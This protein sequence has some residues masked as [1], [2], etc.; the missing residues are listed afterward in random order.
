MCMCVCIYISHVI[1][2]CIMLTRNNHYL[3]SY[4]A[5]NIL[6]WHYTT[7]YAIFHNPVI[8]PRITE[9]NIIQEEYITQPIIQPHVRHQRIVQ[10]HVT[11]PITQP[12]IQEQPIV[13]IYVL[14]YMIWYMI[15]YLVLLCV[16]YCI[17]VYNRFMY[18]WYLIGL[19]HRI[20]YAYVR[21]H[22]S[23]VSYRTNLYTFSK[24]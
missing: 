11:Q 2:Q 8:Q 17:W 7:L 1:R 9:K 19:L 5:S 15:M 22:I 12:I 18:C 24:C 4:H 23:I 20:V 14:W 6:I 21:Y 10:P 16:P 13:C 3:I